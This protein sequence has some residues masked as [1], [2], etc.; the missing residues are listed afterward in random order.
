[1][2]GV[3]AAERGKRELVARRGGGS[4]LG[5]IARRFWDDFT[6]DSKV[7][8]EDPEIPAHHRG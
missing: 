6:P 4:A 3:G 5:E 8:R 1:M 7:A 2:V